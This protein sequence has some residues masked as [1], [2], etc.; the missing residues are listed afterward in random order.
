MK[1]RLD[2]VLPQN[3]NCIYVCTLTKLLEELHFATL[4]DL[5]QS[6]KS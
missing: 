1:L 6:L 3:V 4:A 2:E 5:N